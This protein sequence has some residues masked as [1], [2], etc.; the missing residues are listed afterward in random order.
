MCLHC[1]VLEAVFHALFN[2]GY[3]T[4]AFSHPTYEYHN[5]TLEGLYLNPPGVRLIEPSR[6]DMYPVY[7]GKL[8][9]AGYR[10]AL[11]QWRRGRDRFITIVKAAEVPEAALTQVL[12]VRKERRDALQDLR[13]SA[14]VY[15]RALWD[16]ARITRLLKLEMLLAEGGIYEQ[17]LLANAKNRRAAYIESVERREYEVGLANTYRQRGLPPPADPLA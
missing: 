16:E 6:P 12:E 15:I 1:A 5:L 13:D 8:Q 14:R 10:D 11:S 17:M 3:K 7:E 9:K 4:E 2:L